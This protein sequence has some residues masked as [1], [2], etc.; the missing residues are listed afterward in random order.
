MDILNL[1]IISALRKTAAELEKGNRYEWGHMGSCN[2]GNLAQTITNFS[3][4]EIQKYALEKRG[5][6]TN[7]LLDYCPTSGYPMD[8]IIERMLDF[9]FSQLDLRNLE[10]L[11]DDKILAKMNVT[12]LNRNLKSDTILYFKTWAD[13]LENEIIDKIELPNLEF[14]NNIESLIK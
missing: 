11:S 8:M 4:A 2:C 14:S 3:R 6:W 9:G 12:F 13:L 10:W 5:D 7:Q 1:K